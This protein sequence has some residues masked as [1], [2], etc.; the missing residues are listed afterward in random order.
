MENYVAQT[1]MINKAPEEAGIYF[2]EIN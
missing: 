2:Y 1:K